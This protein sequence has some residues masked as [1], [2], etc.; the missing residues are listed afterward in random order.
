MPTIRVP[1]SFYE[2]ERS[3]VYSN[4]TQ[5]YWRELIQNSVDAGAKKISIGIQM[6]GRRA[7]AAKFLPSLGF[8]PTSFSM[9]ALNEPVPV[10]ESSDKC[11]IDFLDDGPGMSRDVLE[12]VY[13]TLGASEKGENSTGGFGRARILTCFSHPAWMLK[14][15]DWVCQSADDGTGY[16][17]RAARDQQSGLLVQVAVD[18]P[19]HEMEQALHSVLNECEVPNLEVII[20]GVKFTDMAVCA[21]TKRGERLKSLL[22]EDDAVLYRGVGGACP[23]YIYVRVNGLIMFTEY[24][25]GAGDG[26]GYVLELNPAISRKL[27]NANRDSAKEPLSSKIS[28][29]VSDLNRGNTDAAHEQKVMPS[30]HKYGKGGPRVTMTGIGKGMSL[31]TH[32]TKRNKG[33]DAS[34][35]A[36]HGGGM[37]LSSNDARKI[38]KS[39]FDMRKEN[40]TLVIEK[41][42]EDKDPLLI[43]LEGG[44]IFMRIN[45]N[46]QVWHDGAEKW[47]PS[48]WKAVITNTGNVG[49]FPECRP[50]AE[51]LKAW[52]LACEAG[53]AVLSLVS[54][55]RFNF[56]TGFVIDPAL[57]ACAMRINEVVD[58][59]SVKGLLVNPLYINEQG[60]ADNFF[61]LRTNDGM[62]E[63]ICVALHE[64][65]HLAHH[66]HDEKY[67]NVLTDMFSILNIEELMSTIRN[68]L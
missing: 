16:E 40:N 49:W 12:R 3:Q 67:A 34:R 30:L 54:G 37:P 21:P 39:L 36:A 41:A 63:L 25:W 65:A 64:V 24:L 10:V 29:L 46:Q 35:R 60:Q 38:I 8:M 32:M 42:L 2:K 51:L 43:Y 66:Q 58:G 19:P 5:A 33:T 31:P 6:R 52:T 61:D 62:R 11:L 17:L 23:G 22:G 53:A 59:M 44:S 13:M 28:A 14:S 18:T 48:N 27:L 55:A 15:Q 56:Y 57:R 20:N 68:R 45:A 47:T 26:A 7:M 4:W 9:A 1:R 50:R